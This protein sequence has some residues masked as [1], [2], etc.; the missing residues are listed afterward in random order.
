M[1]VAMVIVLS[2]Q[3][4]VSSLSMDV[5]GIRAPPEPTEEI[6]VIDHDWYL[7]YEDTFTNA[8]IYLTGNL[9]ITSSGRLE[10]F[11]SS[12]VMQGP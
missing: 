4:V 1:V 10:L 3:P 7:D 6:I 9:T 11:N 5:E 12:L 2:I 8:T